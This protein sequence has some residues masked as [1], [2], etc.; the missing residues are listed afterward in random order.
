MKLTIYLD[1]SALLRILFG[2]P[3]DKAPIKKARHVLSS[4][5]LRV[6]TAQAVNRA[7]LT[8]Q[9]DDDEAAHKAKELRQLLAAM[10]F[11]EVHEDILVRAQSNFGVSVRAV[12]A[13]HVASAL[14]IANMPKLEFWTH[15]KRQGIA[16][17]ASGLD[18]R[19]V[20]LGGA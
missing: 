14:L 19:G 18:V 12:D 5:L 11:I 15:D 7:R 16:A 10:S 4:S 2:E 13:M 20:D 9:I 6:E 1:S 17:L 3:G 8:E